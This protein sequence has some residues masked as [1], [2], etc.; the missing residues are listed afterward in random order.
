MKEVF[1]YP[2]SALVFVFPL[3]FLLHF[4]FHIRSQLSSYFILAMFDDSKHTNNRSRT[5]ALPRRACAGF[6]P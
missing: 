1:I 2:C 4:I 3:Y 6:P 5:R